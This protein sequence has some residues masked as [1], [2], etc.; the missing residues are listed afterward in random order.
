MVVASLSRAGW[1]SLGVAVIVLG[2]RELDFRSMIRKHPKTA[3]VVCILLVV[4]AAGIFFLK[5][6]SAL[7]RFH[8]WNRRS[9]FLC[10]RPLPLPADL[11]HQI[12]LP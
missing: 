7:G 5:K 4:A 8:I 12:P 2:F 11:Y 9:A 6:E 10:G 3:A 1:L